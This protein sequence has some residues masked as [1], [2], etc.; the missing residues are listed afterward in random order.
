M[1]RVIGFVAAMLIFSVVDVGT[2]Y[3]VRPSTYV[4]VQYFG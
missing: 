1:N 3:N 2:A 4:H